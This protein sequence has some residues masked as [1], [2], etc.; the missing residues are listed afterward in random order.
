MNE[1]HHGN[2]R[3]RETDDDSVF[4]SDQSI[5]AAIDAAARHGVSALHALWRRRGAAEWARSASACRALAEAFG[6]LGECILAYDVATETLE[7]LPGDLRLR[8]LKA[9]ALARSGAADEANRL[10]HELRRKGPA[11]VETF[12]ILARTH[13]DLALSA[14]N[15]QAREQELRNAHHY[16]STA[17]RLA[18]GSNAERVKKFWTGINAATTALLISETRLAHE[19]ARE[20]EEICQEELTRN[21]ETSRW[22]YSALATLGEAAL[23][24]GERAQALKWYTQAMRTGQRRW[25]DVSATRRS[26]HLLVDHLKESA[27]EFDAALE[28]PRVIIFAGHMIDGP[29]RSVPRFPARLE[30]AVKSALRHVLAQL[31]AGFGYSS[32]ACGSDILFLETMLE[33]DA[34]SRV[35]LPYDK[36]EFLADSVGFVPHA[37]WEERLEDALRQVRESPPASQR[38]LKTGSATYEY[39]NILLFGLARLRAEQLGA[40]LRGVAVWDGKPG[41]GPGGTA[42]IV[43]RWRNNGVTVNLID[44]TKLASE[45]LTISSAATRELPPD[46]TIEAP[47]MPVEIK[48]MLFADVVKFSHLAEDQFEAFVEHFLGAAAELATNSKH[49]PGWKN[50][51]GDAFYFVFNRVQDA[52]IFA[53]QLRD[54]LCETDWEAKRLPKG[55]SL[56]IALHAGPVFPCRNPVREMDDFIGAHVNRAARLE[57]VTPAGQV[58]ATEPF[59][60]MA[61]AER[62]DDFGWDYVGQVSLPKGAGTFPAYHI[63]QSSP[64][65]SNA[66]ASGN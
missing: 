45:D 15:A 49:K 2:E 12:G 40:E 14:P 38:R 26:M 43:A 5:T 37:C 7:F 16:Y 52:G 27:A 57:P 6:D 8:Q 60:A 62:I 11:D 59:V 24:L 33:R 54:R 10:L 35:M 42:S 19:L 29:R 44:V 34:E 36:Q 3:P 28:I 56:R 53:L 47:K 63:R 9:L 41:D 32:G 1:G 18:K 13:K 21:G 22:A 23:V 4:A 25:G 48:A 46:S 61:A 30:P 17:F 55:L 51:W 39:T 20:V 31:N 64:N 50:T 65:R 58:Y 66:A